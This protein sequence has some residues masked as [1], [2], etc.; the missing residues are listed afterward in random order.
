MYLMSNAAR[1]ALVGGPR[2]VIARRVQQGIE[3]YTIVVDPRFP[4]RRVA[5]RPVPPEG[6]PSDAAWIPELSF[7]DRTGRRRECFAR[8][9][10]A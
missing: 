3:T 5:G 7:S 8:K 9:V 2:V 6:V 4:L 1:L 10:A